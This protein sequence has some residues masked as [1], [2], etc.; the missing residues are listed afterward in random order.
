MD[1]DVSPRNPKTDISTKWPSGSQM[2]DIT[3]KVMKTD[4]VKFCHK[5]KNG[6]RDDD[7]DDD[8][9]D[10]DDD[11]GGGGGGGR[12]TSTKNPIWMFV[13]KHYFCLSALALPPF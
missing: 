3:L 9:D 4:F 8:D 11:W 2:N 13:N 7:N 5:T 1:I 12:K 6:K 10:D